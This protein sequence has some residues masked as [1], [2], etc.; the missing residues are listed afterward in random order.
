MS[1]RNMLEAIFDVR[2]V[3]CTKLQGLWSERD[4]IHMGWRRYNVCRLTGRQTRAPPQEARG[5]TLEFVDR[6][7]RHLRF[8]E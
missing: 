7:A 5:L 1:E 3:P 6:E 8:R 4:A 2:C